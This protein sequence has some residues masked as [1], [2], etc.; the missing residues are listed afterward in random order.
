MTVTDLGEKLRLRRV[1]LFGARSLKVTADKLGVGRSYLNEIERG[2]RRH[3]PSEVLL[4]RM[5]TLYG[6][7]GEALVVECAG[8]VPA[9]VI[10]ML[11]QRTELIAVVRAGFR[12]SGGLLKQFIDVAG[13]EREDAG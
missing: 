10:E 13:Q 7:D 5:A 6:L 9:E 8:Q 4:R 2:V 12:A 3:P 1:E 11:R